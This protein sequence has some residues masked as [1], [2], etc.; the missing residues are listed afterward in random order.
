[1]LLD[2]ETPSRGRLSVIHLQQSTYDL[3]SVTR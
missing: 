1:M 2:G 3:L